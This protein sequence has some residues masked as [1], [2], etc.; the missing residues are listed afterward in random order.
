MRQF[1]GE[2][3]QF[4]DF[5]FN[6]ESFFYMKEIKHNKSQYQDYNLIQ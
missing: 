3:E 2:D 5:K 6:I 4:K 1:T